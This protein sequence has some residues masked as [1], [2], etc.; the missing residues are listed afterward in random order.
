MRWLVLILFLSAGL[1]AQAVNLLVDFQERIERIPVALDLGQGQVLQREIVVTH[2][3]PP[4]AGPFPLVILNHGRNANRAAQGRERMVDLANYFV[5]RGFA[6]FVPTRV[7][8]GESGTDIDP[9]SVG[10]CG[11]RDFS[12]VADAA[13]Q[14]IRATHAFAARQSWVDARRHIVVGQSAGGLMSV[15]WASTRPEG[16]IATINFAGG[17]G[18]DPARRPG[19]PCQGELLT[20]LYRRLGKTSLAPSLWVYTENDQFF[21][22]Q[23][24][25]QWQATFAEGGSPTR[26]MLLPAFS[27]NG[28]YLVS[29]GS[30][31]WRPVL[32]NY[33]AQFGIE[34][35]RTHGAPAASGYASVSDFSRLPLTDER[36]ERLYRAFLASDP[37]R[38]FAISEDGH[39]AWRSSLIDPIGKALEYCNSISRK[40]CHLYAVD[41]SVVW[42][43]VDV[44]P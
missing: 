37:P 44:K 42:Q 14:Q 8:Y 26:F 5:R 24:S 10:N 41:D 20:E 19:D 31:V 38:A 21:G 39:A 1:R 35:P 30:A 9:E 11:N 29:R 43:D 33:L 32:D 16:L 2:Y 34:R 22:P 6:V 27:S 12:H 36:R 15:A 28:H 7:G 18:G 17:V 40:P 3:R 4:G 13:I 23:F 25:R